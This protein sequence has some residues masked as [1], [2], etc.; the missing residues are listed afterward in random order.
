[1]LARPLPIRDVATLGWI[2]LLGLHADG[3]RADGPLGP[4]GSPITTSRYSIDFARGTVLSAS[5][6]TGLAGASSA[7]AEG[8]EGGLTNPAS[9]AVRS[10]ASVDFW[11]Y[12]LALGFTYPLENGDY[13]NDGDFLPVQDEASYFFLNPGAYLQLWRVGF[14]LDVEVQQ[15][16]LESVSEAGEKRTMRLQLVSNHVQVGSLF[17]DGSLVVGGGLQILRERAATGE[18]E[19]KLDE[20]FDE[21][22][23]G[24]ELGVLIRPNGKQWRIGGGLYT[25]VTAGSRSSTNDLVVGSLYLPRTAVRP[26]QGSLAFAYQFGPRPFN[27][28]F[29]YVEE[30][31]RAPLR[32]LDRKAWLEDRAHQQRVSAIRA[33][34]E[35]DMAERLRIEGASHRVAQRQIAEE[36]A[37]LRKDTWRRLRSQVRTGWPRHYILLT[38]ELSL[39]GRVDQGVGVSSFAAGTVQRSGE[40]VS[41]TPRAA[42]ETEVWPLWMKVRG[43]MYLEPSRVRES[44]VRIHGTFG[45]DVRLFHWD[46]FGIW[47]DD[48]LWQLSLAIDVTDGYVAFSTS[49]GGWY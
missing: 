47:P 19:E 46:V 21:R 36:R 43:G 48:Y 6:V 10:A 17:L 41:V 15:V 18:S 38:T 29:T 4:E 5:R 1:M 42:V 37:K 31:A 28:R 39:T 35:P 26:W 20:L 24:G 49:L 44:S 40:K 25:S 7:I 3:A 27:P 12:W 23:Y 9:V 22:G 16:Q 14:G 2:V 13:Y 33:A 34:Q 11:D 30:E 45:G 8:A 32:E